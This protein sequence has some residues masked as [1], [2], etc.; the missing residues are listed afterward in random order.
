MSDAAN[1]VEAIFAG[2]IQRSDPAARVAFVA[3]ACGDDARLRV[4]VAALLRAHDDAASGFLAA[5]AD[6]SAAA[7]IGPRPADAAPVGVGPGSMVGRYKL[8][9]QIGEGGF[10]VVYMAE[11]SVPVRRRVAVKVIKAGMDSRS[12]VARFEAERQALALMDHPNIARVLDAGATDAGRPYFVMELV[13]GI[14]ITDYCDE[15]NL[16]T[17][18][19]L[20][21]FVD[22]CR[23]V[24]HAH[25][26]GIIHRDLKPS[27]ILVTLHDGRP[28]VKVIDFGIAKATEQRLT[29]LT[30]FTGFG[31][32]IGT[33]AYMSPEQA[34]I[35]GLD[36]DTRSDVYSLGVLLYELLAGS[37]P[38]DAVTLRQAGFDEMRRI[39]R[40]QPP[41][42]PST[43][44]GT[45]AADDR[46]SVAARRGANPQALGRQL[47]GDLDW[48]V[49][50][51]I[52]KDR[53]RRYESA[54]AFAA[55]V[56]RHLNAEAVLAGAPGAI[57]RVRKFARRHRGPVAAAAVVLLALVG[58]LAGTTFGLRRAV[59]ARD[60]EAA[61][62]VAAERAR[63]GEAAARVAARREA[64]RAVAAEAQTRA[65]AEELR[66]VAD[67]QA[68]MLAGVD[69]TAMG[70]KLTHDVRDRVDAA[71]ASAEASAGA[72]DAPRRVEA[73][74]FARSW[75][76]V[77]ATDLCRDLVDDAVLRPAVAAVDV[78]FIAQP[79][80]AAQLREGIAAAYHGL[81]LYATA[82]SLQQQTLAYRRRALPPGHPETV[83][84]LDNVGGDLERLGRLGEAEAAY[85]EAL[86]GS[87]RAYG[88]GHPVTLQCAADLGEVLMGQNRLAEAEPYLR[89][90]RDGRR[91]TLGTRHPDTLRSVRAWGRLLG[92]RGDLAAA[93]AAY[94][95]AVADATAALGPDH[96][97]TL[98]ATHDLAVL[99]ERQG[100]YDEAVG[101][102][103][104]LVD[105]RRRLLGRVHPTTL[106]AITSLGA[107]LDTVGHRDEAEQLLRE[108]LADQRRL[109]GPDHAATLTT[110]GNLSVLLI[111]RGRLTEA[112]A[113]ARQT[114]DGRRRV[115]GESHPTTLIATNV[116]ALV[117]RQQGRVAEAEPYLRQ[118][119]DVAR[120]TL[121]PAHP[122]ALR[123]AHNL[124]VFLVDRGQTA[125]AERL[126]RD[127]VRTGGP[128]IG[129]GHPVV[130]SAT[131]QLG[132]LLLNRKRDA[133]A[134][135]LL[136]PA[137]PF[138]RQTYTGT[139]ESGLAGF[140]ICLGRAL[141]RTGQ[142]TPA[143][144]DLLEAYAIDARTVGPQAPAT[145]YAARVLHTFYVLWA[146]A[147]PNGGHDAQAAK[148]Q[149]TLARS[150]A[151][152]RPAATQPAAPGRS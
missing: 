78:Q 108:A 139:G 36:L 11:Q 150:E 131:A 144:S 35:S 51:A 25:Q 29:E 15:A 133:D 151:A 141:N 23:A 71:L 63:D 103:R 92:E 18:P 146:G 10:G 85:R 142:R 8:L 152:T 27:N 135:D 91:R 129:R 65:R 105:A 138:A 39:I 107:V 68:R 47:S 58:G 17:R 115:L 43:R 67:F 64:D 49:L 100:K 5:T 147:D 109:L 24:Q 114:L 88:D 53:V 73:E 26:R 37:P 69:P 119:V 7:A 116:M 41:A 75:G 102:L 30:L 125:E 111:N 80:A 89:E 98:G 148:W 149:A 57:Y 124:A 136:A 95:G 140:L 123:Y 31:Q 20:G 76:R 79:A 48:I 14:P 94:R 28:V 104:S 122:D 22:V 50:K 62:K 117:L 42:K 83:V 44:L 46:L 56:E 9:E 130:L 90:A 45:L 61:A 54:S 121:G 127:V 126:F 6:P 74:A 52:E 86:A 106:D 16:P 128:A 96:Q 77:N 143:E 13:K 40:E 4:R 82:L 84:A 145:L 66:K 12:V 81:G 3:A 55:D 60:A 21:L 70:L 59:R 33:P 93:E 101:L 112:E 32:M 113:A 134:V 99:L 1:S 34:V 137:E 97:A 72:G 118:L 120:R 132:E 110:L 19:R 2:A 87:R 38:F